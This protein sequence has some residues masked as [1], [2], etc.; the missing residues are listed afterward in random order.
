MVLLPGSFPAIYCTTRFH[1]EYH[2]SSSHTHVY[3]LRHVDAVESSSD[4]RE[5]IKQQLIKSQ[6]VFYMTGWLCF[7]CYLREQTWRLW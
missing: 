7:T 4:P 6:S 2:K 1:N 3:A 5:L